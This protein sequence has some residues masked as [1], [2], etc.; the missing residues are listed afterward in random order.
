HS[1][2][3]DGVEV[4]DEDPYSM[5]ERP[6]PDRHRTLGIQH[7]N[8]ELQVEALRSSRESVLAGTLDRLVEGHTQAVRFKLDEASQLIGRQLSG[9]ERR[10]QVVWNSERGRNH[11]LASS[12]QLPGLHAGVIL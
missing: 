11:P 5:R 4:I 10:E 2:V 1:R 3:E 8:V 6:T 9:F 12:W 7:E